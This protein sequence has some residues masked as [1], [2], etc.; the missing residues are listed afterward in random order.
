MSYNGFYIHFY[1]YTVIYN[2]DTF[3]YSNVPPII[4]CNARCALSSSANFLILSYYFSLYFSNFSRYYRDKYLWK[5]ISYKFTVSTLSLFSN[6]LSL[7]TIIS[8]YL[9]NYSQ[10]SIILLFLSL[11]ISFWFCL[12]LISLLNSLLNDFLINVIIFFIIMIWLRF[13]FE[14]NS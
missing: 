14:L 11:I 5:G 7:E 12:N 2:A 1:F 10:I 8:F 3:F 9:F 4:F 13:E 6:M